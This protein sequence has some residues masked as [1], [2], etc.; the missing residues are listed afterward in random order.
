MIS[1]K[2]VLFVYWHGLGD[3][4]LATPAIKEY[5]KS[6]GNFIGWAMLE[7]FRK[8]EL[9]R[10]NPYI[11]QLHYIS[12]AWNDF[13]S[14][15]IGQ[16]R[17]I[18]ECSEIADRAGYDEMII[19]NH[20]SSSKH[21]I[22]R[23]ADEM[24]VKLK[25]LHTEFYGFTELTDY[26]PQLSQYKGKDFIFYHGQAGVETKNFPVKYVKNYLKQQ[27]IN[28]PILTPGVDW[29]IQ[30]YP[31][32]VSAFMMLKARY[33]IVTDSVMYHIAHALNLKI[34]LAYFQR[35]HEVWKIVHP[36][37]TSNEKIIYRLI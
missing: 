26:L 7:R 6:T 20:Q 35:G 28:L 31:I 2:K 29:S 23:I 11:D 37:H 32:S 12:D 16:Q 15:E 18:D 21:K 25:D 10:Y 19:I 17:V 27:K 5:K 22:L 4:I 1:M 14:Y 36:L 34:D 3:N 24:K 33:R 9:F 30:K 13:K 8:T